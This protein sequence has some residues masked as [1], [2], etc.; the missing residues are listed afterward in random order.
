MTQEDKNTQT[1]QK[2]YN[3]EPNIEA[4]LSYLLS[5]FSG[6]FVFIMEKQNKFVRFHAFQSILFG[7]VAFGAWSIAQ[8]LKLILIGF[9]IEPVVSILIA[10]CWFFLMW[11]AYNKVEFEL[12]FLGKIAHDQV[13]KPS[14]TPE[15]RNREETK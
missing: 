6:V 1:F 5:P 7:V 11:K 2:P 14:G 8:S 3:L 12:P 9:L 13:Y 4:A 10:V 15:S